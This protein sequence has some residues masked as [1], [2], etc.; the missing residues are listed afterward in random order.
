MGKKSRGKG[1]ENAINEEI[2]KRI[3]SR[4]CG[5]CEVCDQKTPCGWRQGMLLDKHRPNSIGVVLTGHEVP[6]YGPVLTFVECRDSALETAEV[7]RVVWS[8]AQE[9]PLIVA[10]SDGSIVCALGPET[11]LEGL[12]KAL[13]MTDDE[14]E[15]IEKKKG[16]KPS[17]ISL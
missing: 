9:V 3:D 8:M 11:T 12:E 1:K 16:A 4:D 14:I 7:E 15:T 5:P 17:I 10:K 6:D 2:Q 13:G